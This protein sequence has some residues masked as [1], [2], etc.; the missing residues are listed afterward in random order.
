LDDGADLARVEALDF[1]E[2]D[3]EG[4]EA[5]A[6]TAG[7]F[8][9]RRRGFVVRMVRRRAVLEMIPRNKGEILSQWAF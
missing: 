3:L 4:G 9:H 6:D 7:V 1:F 2:E 5:A 8:E